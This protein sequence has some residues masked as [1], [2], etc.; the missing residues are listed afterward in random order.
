MVSKARRHD[1]KA[2]LFTGPHQVFVTGM[3]NSWLGP[4]STTDRCEQVTSAYAEAFSELLETY[5]HIG[6]TLP[7]FLQYEDLFRTKP[8]MVR[9]LSLMYADILKFHRIALRYFQQPRQYRFLGLP[10]RSLANGNLQ[11]GSSC[12]TRHGRHTSLA[13]PVSSPTWPGIE[14]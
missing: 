8:C 4:V 13:S 9:V 6:E 12:S 1:V 10:L 2:H 14:A 7:L 11:Y 3:I 5:E